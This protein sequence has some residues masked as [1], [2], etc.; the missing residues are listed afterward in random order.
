M[1]T[2]AVT[3]VTQNRHGSDVHCHGCEIV[4][5]ILTPVRVSDLRFEPSVPLVETHPVSSG[6][7]PLCSQGEVLST[8]LSCCHVNPMGTGEKFTPH[9]KEVAPELQ[10]RMRSGIYLAVTAKRNRLSTVSDLSR[11]LCS[12]TGTTVSRQTVYR[13]LRHIG[14]YARRPVRCVPLTQLTVACD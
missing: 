4:H 2:H 11:Q 13:R 14:L 10:R 3:D 7:F 9:P 1:R 8:K 12:G 6:S 5:N